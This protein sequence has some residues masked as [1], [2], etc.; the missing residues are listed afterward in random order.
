M[1]NNKDMC[2]TMLKATLIVIART[3]KHKCPS[4]EEWIKKMWY[5]YT[6]EY[7]T[8]EKNVDILKFAG[9]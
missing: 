4:N 7:Y 3:W 6:V 2:S 5:I 1:L 8:V 9:K